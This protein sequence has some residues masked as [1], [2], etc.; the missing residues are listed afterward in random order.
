MPRG[1]RAQT[2]LGF[3][4]FPSMPGTETSRYTFA[5]SVEGESSEEAF[6]TG[7]LGDF[8][9]DGWL[10][11]LL[12][13][14]YGLL[15]NRGDGAMVPVR[16]EVGLRV[17]GDAGAWEY[18]DRAMVFVDVD[19]D[20]DL[21]VVSGGIDAEL[22]VQE[23]HAWR[24]D[25]MSEAR[26]HSALSIVP[27]DL[28]R[29]GDVDLVVSCSA[30][31]DGACGGPVDFDV[32]VND[33][34]GR[35]VDEAGARGLALP[36]GWFVVGAVSGDLD[37]DGDFDLITQRGDG[38]Q[39]GL[40]VAINDGSGRFAATFTPFPVGC[41]GL[42]QNMALGDL[43]GDG[44]LDLV[45]GRCPTGAAVG[46]FAGP[47]V[48][49]HPTVAHVVALN[50]GTGVFTD[51]SSSWWDATEYPAQL[52]GDNATLFDIDYDGDLDF[53][54]F[55]RSDA[56]MSSHHLQ[57][58]L[59]DASGHL[60]YSATMS[61]ELVSAGPGVGADLDL[62][63]LDHDG[64]ADAWIGVG[65]GEAILL[66]SDL[67]VTSTGGVAANL[68]QGVSIS[69]R[70][71]LPSIA[72][73]WEI[74]RAA[75][76]ARSFRVYRSLAPSLEDR[77]QTLLAVV[78][79]SAH[80]SRDFYGALDAHTTAA[81]IGDPRVTIS[82]PLGRLVF[83]D[84][85]AV[86]GVTYHYSVSQ[87]GLHH[88]R[89]AHT[90]EVSASLP[91]PSG[92]DERA[93]ELEI[94]SPTPETWE[95]APRIVIT[96]ADGGAGI[97]EGSL[98]VRGSAV[99]AGV[100]VERDLLPLL[101]VMRRDASAFV[102]WFDPSADGPFDIPARLT[103]E[104]ADLAGNVATQ[105][106]TFRTEA[107]PPADLSPALPSAAFTISPLA[108]LAP[109]EA[110]FGDRSHDDGELLRAEWYFDDGTSAIGPRVS[111]LVPDTRTHGVE[112]LVRDA[113]GNVGWT[114][115]SVTYDWRRGPDAG[116][117]CSCAGQSCGVDVCGNS[118]GTCLPGQT[119]ELN[120]C[121][122]AD[123]QT[124]CG[125]VCG[126]DLMTDRDHCGSCITACAVGQ[127]CRNGACEGTP[128]SRTGCGCRVL[129]APSRAPGWPA[130][131][132]LVALWARRRRVS[133]Y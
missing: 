90:A 24:F 131:I 21:D 106:V 115:R 66:A 95:P 92:A 72:F 30:C 122:C 78:G 49:G 93:P 40:H 7:D 6:Y 123:G 36:P 46:A 41:S 73:S 39:A 89:S 25:V 58:F 120:Q 111:W 96:Y 18:G 59:N 112:L 37:G 57:V 109:L 8:D 1:A 132:A 5:G 16:A 29:D 67:D 63:D 76:S 27:T 128:S 74:P 94:V 32:L 81:Q 17:R 50:D 28:E 108:A 117:L 71:G 31:I 126:I 101:R 35:F 107:L 2:W 19:G 15:L 22:V 102:A 133:P 82:A 70:A 110:T 42:G 12:G 77:N 54:A 114:S 121:M 80:L 44:D 55:R 11:R 23:N 129:G 4:D 69:V 83:H 51:V 116:P 91:A 118:C 87:V 38:T 9:G 48:G 127:V 105:Q 33:G 47:Y 75:S 97:D 99:L 103:V 62:G 113:A 88:E 84:A 14:R 56:T 124:A 43:D 85:S 98:R 20:G 86:P 119:C 79:Q 65:S 53:L 125:M 10:D 52:A 3:V 34:T 64:D 130:L 68:P 13:A 100:A 45:A 60:V 104:V 61:R 26:G